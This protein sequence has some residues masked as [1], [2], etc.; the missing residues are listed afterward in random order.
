MDKKTYIVG[1]GEV[2]WDLLPDGSKPGGAPANFAYHISQ[3]GLDGIVVSAIGNDAYGEDLLHVYEEIGLHHSLARVGYPTGTVAVTLDAAGIPQYDITRNVAW[4]HIPFTPELSELAETTSAVCFGSLAQRSP[5]SRET[6]IRFVKAVAHNPSALIVF[7]GNLR[8]D[9]YDLPT[10][11]E[12][13]SLCNIL[14][15]ND[16]ELTVFCRLFG[17]SDTDFRKQC[18]ALIE[19]FDLKILIVTCGATGSY[20]FTGDT[21]SYIPTPRVEVAD[22]VGAGDSFTAAFVANI[23]KG[24]SVTEAHQA[25][26]RTSA[27]VCTRHGAMPVL[28]SDIT[29]I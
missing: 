8:Q 10:V 12:S 11:E 2:L 26:V 29:L 28:P 5:E 22:T 24:R 3:F 13:L 1:I 14:K 4:D 17:I 16:E 18:L 20:V 7:D 27:Y 9:F 23:L 19:M 6:I 15:I 25:A 21:E